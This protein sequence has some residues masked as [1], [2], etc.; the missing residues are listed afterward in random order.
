MTSHLKKNRFEI[1]RDQVLLC[2]LGQFILWKMDG[3][4]WPAVRFASVPYIIRPRLS[5]EG[6]PVC[7]GQWNPLCATS[8]TQITLYNFSRKKMAGHKSCCILSFICLFADPGHRRP[9]LGRSNNENGLSQTASPVQQ[10]TKAF[11]FYLFRSKGDKIRVS[12]CVFKNFY[13]LH[14]TISTRLFFSL[15]KL[16]MMI[17]YSIT[18]PF[19][20]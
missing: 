16:L 15:T 6:P 18:F 3:D 19:F 13:H 9:Y 10:L 14:A 4:E 20:F 5:E 12:N 11:F 1:K 2:R 7:S 17:S 8:Y